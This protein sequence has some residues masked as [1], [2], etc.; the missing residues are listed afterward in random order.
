MNKA[1]ECDLES[2]KQHS[3]LTLRGASSVTVILHRK[4][5]QTI[6]SWLYPCY[7][8]SFSGGSILQ[9]PVG[10]SGMAVFITNTPFLSFWLSTAHNKP[11]QYQHEGVLYVWPCFNKRFTLTCTCN[12]SVGVW[13]KSFWCFL[14]FQNVLLILEENMNIQSARG[15]YI[16][17]KSISG[18]QFCVKTFTKSSKNNFVK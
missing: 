14:P 10:E 9:C 16:T 6:L 15:C 13:N 8:V 4:R 17:V 5:S 12:R 18:I 3:L 1:P 2:R 7:E 11:H